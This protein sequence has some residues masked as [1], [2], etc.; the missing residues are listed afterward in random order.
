[1]C[2]NYYGLRE[3]R[4]G[5]NYWEWEDFKMCHEGRKIWMPVNGYTLTDK[6]YN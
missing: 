1:M 3:D 4:I 6:N 5:G 2:K